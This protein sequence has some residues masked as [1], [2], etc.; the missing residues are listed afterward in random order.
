MQSMSR[1]LYYNLARQY[2]ANIVT[3]F[4]RLELHR[5]RTVDLEFGSFSTEIQRP[6]RAQQWYVVSCS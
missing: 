1:V 2:Y 5:R 3:C 6:K 4:A